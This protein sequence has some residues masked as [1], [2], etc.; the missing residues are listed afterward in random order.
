[1]ERRLSEATM[2]GSVESLINLIQ[3]DPLILDKAIASCISQSPLH[4]SSLLGHLDFTTELLTRKPEF[5]AELDSEG[6]SP[7]HLAAAKGH[8]EIVKQLLLAGPEMG[9]VRNSDGRTPLHV[10]AIK[11]RVEVVAEL[12]R[13]VP[14]STRAVTDRGETG[15]HLCVRHNRLEAL[16][17]LAEVMRRE[18]ELVN[19]RDC[20]GNTILHIAVAKKQI[21][22]IKFLLNTG[23]VEVNPLNRNGSTCLDILKQSPRDLRDSEIDDALRHAGGLTS[24]DLHLIKDE[25]VP[26]KVPQIAKRLSSHQKSSKKPKPKHKHT[27]WLASKRSALMVVAS[28]IAT[29][30]FQAGLTPPGGV[31]QDDYKVDSN[32][33]PVAEPHTVGTA[34]M[35]YKDPLQYGVFMI[36]N[37]IAFL[38]SLSVILLL[39][40]GLPLKRR[41]WMW[42]QMV[43]MWVSITALVMTYFISLRNMSPKTNSAQFM[44]RKVTEI[45][46]LT[47]LTLMAVVFIGNIVRMNLWI[48]RKYGYIKEK[49]RTQEEIDDERRE[50]EEEEEEEG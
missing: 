13:V 28:L 22:I 39:V 17:F 40:S 12:V 31:W 49:E 23:A 1:M 14:E 45:S 33:K 5:A 32:G 38:A 21:E 11:G 24:K 27:D 10:A 34:V 25:W 18:R 46:I 47:W 20:E 8:L 6:C 3:E 48:L 42:F 19:R 36:F 44:L 15:L 30:A 2:K 37:T 7:L 16:K 41:R 26:P 43:I 9:L 50:E 35:A 29:V 4:L